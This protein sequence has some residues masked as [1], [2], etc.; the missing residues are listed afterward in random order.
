MN[1]NRIEAEHVGMGLTV[2]STHA[3]MDVHDTMSVDTSVHVV[4]V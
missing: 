3:W 2:L 4:Y 1:V